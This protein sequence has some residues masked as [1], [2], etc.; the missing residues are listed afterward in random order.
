MDDLL[1]ALKAMED[2]ANAL[3]E[4]NAARTPSA[5]KALFSRRAALKRVRV[6]IEESLQANFRERFEEANRR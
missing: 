2:E 4:A 3:F 1:K 5:Q 6:L